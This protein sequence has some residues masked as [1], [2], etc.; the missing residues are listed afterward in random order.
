MSCSAKPS[1]K[2]GGEQHV[3]CDEPLQAD[4]PRAIDYAHTATGD[5][6][7]EFVIAETMGAA[8]ARL[9]LTTYGTHGLGGEGRLALR[10]AEGPADEAG[11]T[12][13][14][15]RVRGQSGPA[16]ITNWF[17]WHDRPPPAVVSI[18]LDLSA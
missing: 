7:K 10:L 2:L 15:G 8:R 1:G 4:L 9:G 5:F 11:G 18:I 16:H 12:R 3:Y 14:T 6:L 17:G 13:L